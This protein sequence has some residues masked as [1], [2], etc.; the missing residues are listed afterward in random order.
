M[1]KATMKATTLARLI[2]ECD[3]HALTDYYYFQEVKPKFGYW[4]MCRAFGFGMYDVKVKTGMY[5]IFFSNVNMEEYKG[6]LNRIFGDMLED[7]ILY[8][9]ESYIVLRIQ[10]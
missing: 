6:I 10:D 9:D 3:C 7:Y 8:K 1:K 5:L 4:T 2:E